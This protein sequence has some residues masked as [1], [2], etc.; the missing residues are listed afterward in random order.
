[1]PLEEFS[2][3]PGLSV[4]KLTLKVILIR[5]F[6]LA[7]SFTVYLV[8]FIVFVNNL[9]KLRSEKKFLRELLALTFKNFVF[10]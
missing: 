8:N 10:Y 1:M 5:K 9:G 7:K 6:F 3:S 4:F 2:C